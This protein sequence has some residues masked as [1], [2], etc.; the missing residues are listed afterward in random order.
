MLKW[1]FKSLPIKSNLLGENITDL[2]RLTVPQL[3]GLS[4]G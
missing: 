1:R 3:T 2:S 4:L